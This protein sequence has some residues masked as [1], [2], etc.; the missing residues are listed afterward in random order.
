MSKY[1]RTFKDKDGDKDKNKNKK[2]SFSKDDYNLLGKYKTIWIKIEDLQNIE[3]N[4]LP[5]YDQRYTTKQKCGHMAIKF[6]LI[7]A[8]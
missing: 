6:I 1:V 5:V 4:D 8:V 3:L 7:L 2:M